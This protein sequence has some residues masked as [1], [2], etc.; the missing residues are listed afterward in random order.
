MGRYDRKI[1]ILAPGPEEREAI[2]RALCLKY[3]IECP[4]DVSEVVAETDGWTGAEM[5]ARSL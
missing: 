4:Q 2:L 5:E 3:G 1:P